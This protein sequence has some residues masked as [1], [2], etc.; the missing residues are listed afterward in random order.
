MS[1]MGTV[2]ANMIE[3]NKSCFAPSFEGI[4]DS[5]HELVGKKTEALARQFAATHAMKVKVEIDRLRS[6]LVKLDRP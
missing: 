3:S 4:R 6:E 1:S 5:V 2:T